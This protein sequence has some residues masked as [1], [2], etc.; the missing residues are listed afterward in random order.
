M[1]VGAVAAVAAAG[2]LPFPALLGY[3]TISSLPCLLQVMPYV[4]LCSQKAAHLT[5]LL[6][7]TDWSVK[8]LFGGLGGAAI[9]PDTGVNISNGRTATWC[10][11]H[12]C[13]RLLQAPSYDNSLTLDWAPEA[14]SL[15][16]VAAMVAAVRAVV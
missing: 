1:S 14:R 15:P 10:R 5:R 12:I 6:E 8:S 7:D 13:T 2:T 4:S 16:G 11:C 3:F 9:T